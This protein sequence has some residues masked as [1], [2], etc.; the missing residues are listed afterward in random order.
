MK[1]Y[2]EKDTPVWVNGKKIVI[3]AG[4]QD[5]DE[6]IGML[7]IHAGYARPIEERTEEKS[8]KKGS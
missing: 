6:D 1:I 3:Q 4:T 5:V 7:L 2:V 8:K